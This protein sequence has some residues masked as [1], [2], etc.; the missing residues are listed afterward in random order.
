MIAAAA[1]PDA[2]LRW[3]AGLGD[4]A[5]LRMLRLLER[6][7][8]GVGDLKDVVQ[9]PQSTVSRHLKV[10]ADEGWLASR[11]Q[12]TTRLYRM[13]LDELDPA[14]RE[15]WLLAREQTDDWAAVAQD[16]VRLASLLSARRADAQAF[17]DSV[18]E[19]WDQRRE[20]LYGRY[21][22]TQALLGLLPRAWA[23]ADLGCGTGALLAELAP[24]VERVIGVD[25]SKAMLDAAR[26]R[27]G[28]R[29]NV[30]LEA[31]DLESLPLGDGCCDAALLVLVLAYL[32]RPEAA[33]AEACRV[34]KP[35]GRVVVVDLLRHD[36]DDFRREHGQ[37]SM[38]FDPDDL[39]AALAAAGFDD[40]SCRP[41]PPDPDAEGPALLLAAA[42]RP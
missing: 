9:M 33:L 21:F 22:G 28:G 1:Q 15:L 20:Q 35:G 10:L 23:V 29:D 31:G 25:N 24:Q 11:R 34:V 17:F 40:P 16:R 39:T 27:L 18:A 41:L 8:L 3:M 5:R 26:A 37:Q 6:Q 30:T 32:E 14:Q 4:P 13:L 42:T 2:L 12:G 19:A 38:G 7:E 36:R